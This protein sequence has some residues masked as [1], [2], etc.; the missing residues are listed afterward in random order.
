MKYYLD[1]AEIS[2]QSACEHYEHSAQCK[3]LEL[4]EAQRYWVLAHADE[5][6]ESIEIIFEYSDYRLEILPDW[7]Q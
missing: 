4:S 7:G 1:G 5:C 3:G 6:G 2:Q